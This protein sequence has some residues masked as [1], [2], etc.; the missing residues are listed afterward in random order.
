MLPEGRLRSAL[1]DVSLITIHGPW[2]RVVGAHLLR[3]A[4]P[5]A[6]PGSAPQP[7]WPGG[8]LQGA[9]FTPEN[10]FG[11]L[12]LASD[13]LTALMETQAVFLT[14]R[15]E[16]LPANLQPWTLLGV[17]G[18]LT[19]VLDVGEPAIQE[20]LG[21]SLAEL[22]GD[23]LISQSAAGR[24]PTQA[25]GQTAFDSGRIV[26][27]RYAS[28]RNTAKG[29]DV[30]VFAERLAPGGASYLRVVDPHRHLDQRLP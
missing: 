14:T 20:A 11:T 2:F 6:P 9:R 12:Y 4:P 16:L 23:W 1:A 21:T 7:L 5:G 24:S 18:V 26:A 25:L 15:G 29:F 30:A 3:D 22:T 13:P 8:A 17:D 28:A 19:D 10:G 27:I